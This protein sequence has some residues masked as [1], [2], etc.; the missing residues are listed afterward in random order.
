MFGGSAI[1]GA[2]YSANALISP[3]VFSDI[4]V[5]PFLIDYV[6]ILI[7]TKVPIRNAA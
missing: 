7:L 6:D 3:K 5:S 1:M 4:L 2:E